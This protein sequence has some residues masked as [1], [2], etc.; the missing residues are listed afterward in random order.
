MPAALAKSAIAA[1][2]VS[3]ALDLDAGGMTPRDKAGHERE[4]RMCMMTLAEQAPGERKGDI[5]DEKRA[6]IEQTRLRVV[7]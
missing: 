7:E 3:L 4:L 1:S 5:T 6:R 2:A